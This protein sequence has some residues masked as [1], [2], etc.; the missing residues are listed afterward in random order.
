MLHSIAL[1]SFVLFQCSQDFENNSSFKPT[2]R[3]TLRKIHAAVEISTIEA[4]R[5]VDERFLSFCLTWKNRERWKLNASRETRLHALTKALSPAYLRIG[6]TPNNFLR[7]KFSVDE[8]ESKSHDELTVGI[9][10]DDLDRL[11]EIAQNAG[12][13]VLF[14][15]SVFNKLKNGSWGPSNRY[16]V[17]KYVADRGYKFGWELGNELNL[18]KDFN[19]AIP[20]EK[21]ADDYGK[22]KQYFANHPSLE[23]FLVGPDVTQPRGRAMEYLDRFLVKGHSYINAVTWHHYY[24]RSVDSSPAQFYVPEVMDSLLHDMEAVG[25]VVRKTAPGLPIWLGETSSASG[26]G[27]A[28]ISDRYLGGFLW[29]DKLGLAAQQGYKVVIRQS[30]FGGSYSLVGRDMEPNPGSIC[31]GYINFRFTSSV[32]VCLFVFLFSMFAFINY[33]GIT[34]NL[35]PEKA[36]CLYLKEPL[37]RLAVHEY[38]MSPEVDATSRKMK[39]NDKILEMGADSSFPKLEPRLIERGGKII[40]GPLSFAFYVVPEARAHVCMEDG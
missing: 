1:V 33:T 15:L 27:V 2:E 16:E 31:L 36:V 19:A 25:A 20:P 8:K 40:L 7:F 32:F 39:L 28:G 37:K 3:Q 9:N 23:N 6:G 34:M 13:Q 30:L 35:H 26:G 24:V 29:L 5:V 10:E 18:L 14:S 11:H 4:I 21:L 12:L 22:L 17:L 38:L